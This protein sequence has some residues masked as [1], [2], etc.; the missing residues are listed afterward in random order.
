MT[1]FQDPPA[2]LPPPPP[3]P[4]PRSGVEL[5]L[6][7]V[8]HELMADRRSERRWRIFFRLAWFALVT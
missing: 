7:R 3:D 8:A 2:P 6:D 4:A 5:S 1:D